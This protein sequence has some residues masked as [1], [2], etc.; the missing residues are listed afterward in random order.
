MMEIS[1]L[2]N[3]A[4]IKILFLDLLLNEYRLIA[5]TTCE[6]FWVI[7]ISLS[8]HVLIYYNNMPTTFIINSLFFYEYTKVI[9][10]IFHFI[11]DV[12]S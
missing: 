4:K 2:L 3:K 6:H 12:I 5:H 1:I 11:R 10:V 9:K 8:V 7:Y